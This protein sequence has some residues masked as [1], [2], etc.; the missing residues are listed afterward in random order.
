[1]LWEIYDPGL[2]R[3]RC[4]LGHAFTASNLG[5]EQRHA[6]ETALWSGLRALEEIA[7]PH[8]RMKDRALKSHH[9]TAAKTFEER[10]ANITANAHTLRDF[11]LR[12]NENV[13]ERLAME[14]RR[15]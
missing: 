3:F 10:A 4:R 7:S 9:E 13:E 6:T 1:M 5:A 14:D 11:L 12:V 2:L 15:P 8:R